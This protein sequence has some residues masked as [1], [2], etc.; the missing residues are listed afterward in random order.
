MKPRKSLYHRHRFPQDIIRHPVW[1][2]Y[3]F[4]L[5]YRDVDDL[6]A[7]RGIKV[8][9]ETVRRWC[10]RFGTVYAKKLRKRSGPGGDQW[11]VDEV[12]IR[13]GGQQHYLYRAV[14]RDGHILDILVQKRRNKEA[15]ARYFRRLLK[16]QCQAPRRLVTDKLRSYAPA[17]RQVMPNTVHDTSQYANNRAELSHEPTRQRERTMRRFKSMGQAQR[18]LAV[19]GAMKNLFAIPRHL[20]RAKNHRLFRTEAFVPAGDVR[21]KEMH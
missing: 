18:F 8:S 21:L 15:A 7:E 17:H 14:D 1:L 20:L 6:L 11:F 12:Y 19:H 5:S 4:C 3:R 10:I 13:I 16:Q 9:Y 2:Y